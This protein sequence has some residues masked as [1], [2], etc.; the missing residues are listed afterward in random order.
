[1][2][3]KFGA[4]IFI[5]ALSM[6]V[7]ALVFGTFVTSLG[8]LV[9]MG[10]GLVIASIIVIVISKD[11]FSSIPK[12]GCKLLEVVG[13]LSILPLL[14]S[15][16][17]SIFST[18]GVGEVIS[19]LVSNVVP[20]GNIPVAIIVYAVSMVLFTMIMGNAFAA[21]A[22]ITLGIGVPFILNYGLDPNVIGI[23]GLTSGYCGTLMTPMAANFNMLPV[24]ILDIK[25]EYAVIKKQVVMALVMLV[26]QIL[27]MIFL[28]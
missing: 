1:M 23:L 27:L 22:V 11:K 2:A 14:L 19:D 20:A 18:A 21:F 13:T 5:P 9:G 8:S 12:E 15:A 24:A 17:G 28:A 26:V 16:L 10:I 3:E 6:G 4:K 25:D 7:F